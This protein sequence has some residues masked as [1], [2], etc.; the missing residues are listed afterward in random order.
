MITYT[1]SRGATSSVG[2]TLKGSHTEAGTSEINLDS[3]YAASS[4][5]VHLNRVFDVADIQS[6]IIV[7]D[8]NL[9]I[10]TNSGGSPDDTINLVAGIPLEWS[11]SGNYFPCP[12]TVDVTGLYITCTPAARLRGKILLA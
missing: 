9:T 3:Q 12:F 10:E 8:Q 1:V 7:S 5:N 4:A 11:K 6:L 2:A